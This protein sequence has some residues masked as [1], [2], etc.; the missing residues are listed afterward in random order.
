MNAINPDRDIEAVLQ[1]RFVPPSAVTIAALRA[2]LASVADRDGLLDVAYRELDSPYGPL[3]LASTPAGLVRLAF[4]I[5][6]HDAVLGELA[7][8]VSPRILRQPARLDAVSRE[9]DEYFAARRRTFT[10]PVD[11]QLAHGFRYEVLLH[12]RSVPY[13]ATTS[14]TELAA[15]SGSPAA[16]RAVGSACARNPVPLLVPCHRVVRR[17]GTIGDYRGGTEM[18]RALLAMEAAPP[19]G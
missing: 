17:D 7:A 11:L 1:D 2:N 5:E 10:A 9:L 8:A 15:A 4:A 13:G 12:L 6:D 14:Y 19:R 18:K 3:L 16:V